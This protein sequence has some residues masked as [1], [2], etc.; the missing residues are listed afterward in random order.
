MREKSLRH[1]LIFI[2]STIFVLPYLVLCYIYYEEQVTLSPIHFVLILLILALTIIGIIS[3][4]YVFEAVSVTTG[5]LKKAAEG[6]NMVSTNLHQEVAELDEISSSFNCLMERLEKTTE[7]LH[8][9]IATMKKSDEKY[10]NILEN[11]EEGY[12]EV[13]LAGNFTFLNTSMARILGYSME[14]LK[15]M[16]YHQYMDQENA[17]KAFLNYRKVYQTGIPIKDF[18]G[19]LMRKNGNKVFVETS[20]SLIWD[21]YGQAIGFRGLVRDMA[22]HKRMDK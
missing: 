1:R 15:G 14:E 22:E 4:F 21:S 11:I 12:Y 19:E 17:K 18:A 8:K 9:T 6:R 2:I 3:I 16:N 5:L 10:R 13:D 20:V 7:S